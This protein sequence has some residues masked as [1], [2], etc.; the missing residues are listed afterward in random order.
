[1][2]L[3]SDASARRLKGPSRPIQ[4]EGARAQV[5]A[6][7]ESVDLVVLFEADTPLELI[8]RIKPY[9]LV[10]GGDYK[11]DQVVGRDIVEAA[12]GEVILVEPVP[13]R[14]TTKIV[15]RTKKQG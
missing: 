7:L 6:A 8:G 1:M 11:P 3:N 13:E 10:K 2:A 9:V 15:E 12:G 5:L 4:D 14:S